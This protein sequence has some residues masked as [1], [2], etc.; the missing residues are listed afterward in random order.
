MMG[1]NDNFRVLRRNEVKDIEVVNYGSVLGEE[2]F[3]SKVIKGLYEF[4]KTIRYN[5]Y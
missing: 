1:G 2:F 5:Y 3:H 4:K